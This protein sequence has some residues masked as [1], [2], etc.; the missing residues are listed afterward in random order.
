M[1]EIPNDDVV[2]LHDRAPWR[3]RSCS[4]IREYTFLETLCD[5]GT[6]LT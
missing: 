4:L 5:Q 1:Q 6:H 2:L 3:L